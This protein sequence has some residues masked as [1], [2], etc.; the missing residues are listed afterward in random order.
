MEPIS[1]EGVS[2][3]T[4]NVG[5]QP[6]EYRVEEGVKVF[7]ISAQ[8]VLW[9]I[10]DDVMVTAW[11]YNGTVPGPMIRVIEGDRVRSGDADSGS[12][13]VHRATA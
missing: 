10:L 9:N 13:G 3:A 8:P 4:Q 11:T 7:D 6:L 5:G 1:S 12:S 2:P